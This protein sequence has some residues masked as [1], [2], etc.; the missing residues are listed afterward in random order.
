MQ[1]QELFDFRRDILFVIIKLLS[2]IC[3]YETEETISYAN[4]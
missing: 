1:Q 4:I 2:F 3:P